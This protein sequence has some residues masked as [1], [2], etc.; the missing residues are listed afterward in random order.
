MQIRPEESPALPFYP[1][2]VAASLWVRPSYC[3]LD[4]QV[5][6]RLL[7]P[8]GTYVDVGANIGVLARMASELVGP[9]GVVVALEPHPR[10]YRYL[11]QSLEPGPATTRTHRVAAGA[12][13]RSCRITDLRSDDQNRLVEHG[14]DGIPVRVVPLDTLLAGV[15]SIELLKIDT[16]GAELDVLRGASKVL[17]RTRAVLFEANALNSSRYGSS[18]SEAADMLATFGFKVIEPVKDRA[19]TSSAP[20]EYAGHAG[21]LLAVRDVGSWII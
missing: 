16:E 20:P 7:Q 6:R 12:S 5:L 17:E 11:V 3:E 19:P 18:V 15:S 1:S 2:A 9:S 10:T 21:N 4:R 13:S 14:H 8:G